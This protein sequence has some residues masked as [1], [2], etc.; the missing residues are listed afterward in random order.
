MPARRETAHARAALLPP[1]RSC[2]PTCRGLANQEWAEGWRRRAA[3]GRSARSVWRRRRRPEGGWRP[4]RVAPRAHEVSP[5][6]P[7]PKRRSA[8]L[9]AKPAPAKAEPKPKKPAAK[10]K[11]EDKKAPSKGKKGPKGKQAEETNQEQTK[12]NLPAENG[13][14]KNEETPASDAAVEKEAKSE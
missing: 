7:Q 14:T 4:R 1:R 5:C 6:R 13:E 3:V 2:R 12:D 9:S 8:R 10:D 11:S